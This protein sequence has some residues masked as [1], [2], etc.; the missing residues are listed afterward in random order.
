MQVTICKFFRTRA[1]EKTI[2][3]CVMT[4]GSEFAENHIQ[5]TSIDPNRAK[6][7]P[8]DAKGKPNIIQ[9]QPKAEH[10]CVPRACSLGLGVHLGC[11]ASCLVE[12]S[13]DWPGV[14]SNWPQVPSHSAKAPGDFLRT[15]SLSGMLQR[16][17]G[18]ILGPKIPKH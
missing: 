9:I 17:K 6:W 14:P 16:R 12:S 13:A 11:L 18:T 3:I 4:R 7:I 8:K 2:N 1:P 10:V 5:W 15:E